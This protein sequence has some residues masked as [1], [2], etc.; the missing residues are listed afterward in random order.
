MIC[1]TKKDID[2]FA[3]KYRPDSIDGIVGQK[4]VL[5]YF[6]GFI[7][8]KNIPH[9]LFAGQQGTGKT[10]SAIALAKDLF[11][12]E[13][14][15]YFIEINAS[16]DRG[17][18]VVRKKIKQYAR[19][20]IIGSDFK[21]IFLDESDNMT[22]DAQDALRRTMEKYRKQCRFILSCNYPQKIIPPI[23]DRCFT[24]RF[25]R[26]KPED[27]RELLQHISDEENIPISSSAVALLAKLSEGSMRKAVTTLHALKLSNISNITKETLYEITAYVK[28]EDVIQLLNAI[29]KRNMKEIDA[30]VDKLLSFY[31]YEPIEVIKSMYNL[32]KKSKTLSDE[33]KINALMK[34]SDAEWR[35]SQNAS[36]DIQ[37]RYFVMYLASMYED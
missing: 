9:L 30:Q 35:I 11:G 19:Q 22:S 13:W 17:I 8:N 32:I 15:S 4:H 23:A 29:S 20:R 1:I 12:K 24:M 27:M 33:N 37:L 5:P 10:T 36:P 16:D 2:I 14:K 25:R 7:E 18:D 6:E 3:E 34:L 21:I 31:C 26:I 28:E